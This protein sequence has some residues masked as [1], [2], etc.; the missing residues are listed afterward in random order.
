VELERD[1]TEFSGDDWY[2]VATAYRCNFVLQTDVDGLEDKLGAISLPVKVRKGFL[3]NETVGLRWKGKELAET[4]NTDTNLSD[5]LY[6]VDPDFWE[7]KYYRKQHLVR[8]TKGRWAKSPQATFPT[9]EAFDVYDRIAQHIR[10]IA[11]ISH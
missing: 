4:L 1:Q 5:T 2:S 9:A 11:N 10:S 6:R 3:R 7:I 8:I